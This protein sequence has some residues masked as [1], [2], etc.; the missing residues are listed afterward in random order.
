MQKIA[1][2]TIL[3]YL[4][5]DFRRPIPFS[6]QPFVHQVRVSSHKDVVITVTQADGKAIKTEACLVAWKKYIPLERCW[7]SVGN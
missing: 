3:L 2:V 4:E 5:G 1:L 6:F 7:K